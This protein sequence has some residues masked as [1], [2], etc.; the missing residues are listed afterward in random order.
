MAGP[1]APGGAA[2]AVGILL[3]T[4]TFV[5]PYRALDDDAHPPAERYLGR[6]DGA[7]RLTRV[8]EPDGTTTWISVTTRRLPDLLL[9]DVED[10]AADAVIARSGTDA[11]SYSRTGDL[12]GVAIY[13][14]EVVE[15]SALGTTSRAS[16]TM[17][18]DEGYALIGFVSEDGSTQVFDPPLPLLPPDP[19]R[20]STWS[21]EGTYAGAQYRYE[22]EVVEARR[23]RVAV[24]DEARPCLEID[25]VLVLDLGDGDPTEH[26]STEHWC[27]DLGS[28]GYT[29]DQGEGMRHA[30][31]VAADGFAPLDRPDSA[32]AGVAPV[33]GAAVQLGEEPWE[34]T[35]VVSPLG[36][37]VTARPSILPTVVEGPSP[38][39]LLATEA[40]PVLQ[41]VRVGAPE[42]SSRAWTLAT[43]AIAY[44][45]PFVDPEA[46]VVVVGASEGQVRAVTTDGLFLW[47]RD[48]GDN[49]ASRPLLAE[50][51]LV[52]GSESGEVVGLDPGDGTERWRTG[53]GGPV[54]SWPTLLD[55]LVVIG[56]DD[57]VVR[58]I[59]PADGRVRWERD[60]GAGVEAPVVG[61]G[62][63]V[64]VVDRG[65]S[66]T[67]LDADGRVIWATNL[68]GTL[69]T[70][71]VVVEGEQIV[72]AAGAAVSLD[73]R[74]GAERWRLDG[75]F[76]GPGAPLTGQAVVA[77]LDADGT[78]V[79][80][81]ATGGVVE[82][83]PA[84]PAP[85]SDGS[86][87][88][89][90]GTG[91][92]SLW[93][94]DAAGHVQRLGPSQGGAR[95]LPILWAASVSV[96]PFDLELL[97]AAP[98]VDDTGT[99]LIDG[100]GTIVRVDPSTGAVEGTGQLEGEGINVTVA[101]TAQQGTGYVV[102]GGRLLRFA[103]P[104]G[105]TEW[106]RPVSGM[107]MRPPQVVGDAV[108][109]ALEDGPT[110]RLLVVGAADGE[111]RWQR[112]VGTSPVEGA[113]SSPLLVVDGLVIAGDPLGAW[114]LRTGAP[115]W[116]SPATAVL[117]AAGLLP[118]GSVA[119]A[120]VGGADVASSTGSEIVVLDPST[121][122]ERSRT[123][124]PDVLVEGLTDLLVAG[125][126]VVVQ[127]AGRLRLLGVDL[128]S[129]SGAAWAVELP[130]RRLGGA[131]LL[132]DGQVWVALLDGRV[133][134]F[135]PSTGA[136]TGRSPELGID[137]SDGSLVQV[138][139]LVDG[140]VVV[141]AS[142]AGL[143]VAA[144]PR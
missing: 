71:P 49:V 135:D 12:P 58:A 87:V 141:A 51:T 97:Q 131:D 110:H 81:S 36:G 2:V 75:D 10:T 19:N 59:E 25:A 133:L 120:V 37:L 47:S 4:A 70:A 111:L 137:L 95:P 82:R 108:V 77:L 89:G 56:S 84:L 102:T 113:M 142:V 134:A 35:S 103:L 1:G 136:E 26:R 90:L 43:G 30:T 52:M 115:Q 85:G 80:V 122:T 45:A 73:L 91:A 124:L 67:H 22:G 99:Y 44:G 16:L 139:V 50:G 20:G 78:V 27:E 92:G 11:A 42:G 8:E 123:E 128:G 39:L 9:A 79:A 117:G 3:L 68:G 33:A 64:V 18:D 65:G 41:A 57:G 55:G 132:G 60:M 94:A 63:G 74:T 62:E 140:V 54:V 66:V 125:D 15:R 101:A 46:G 76:V 13:R 23:R 109:V 112:E 32:T 48:V 61:V 105:S 138:P 106:E 14:D 31:L 69:R 93:I 98:L 38:L 21:A 130:A 104:D 143:G 114:D 40:N 118:D 88:I 24:V 72:V 96:P 28:V 53:T 86:A 83:W 29:S 129:A 126:R 119:V 116:T 100:G 6:L 144:G 34:R 7:G 107:A 121:G 5:A 17:V 127:D